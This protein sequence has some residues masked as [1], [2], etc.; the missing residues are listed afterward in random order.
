ME[1][2]FLIKHKKETFYFSFDRPLGT[3]IE[4]LSAQELKDYDFTKTYRNMKIRWKQRG[5]QKEFK[6][7]AIITEIT[8][9]KREVIKKLREEIINYF[10]KNE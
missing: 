3:V 5:E 6:V 9:R 7:Y 2:I 4:L 1:R 10:L 8:M